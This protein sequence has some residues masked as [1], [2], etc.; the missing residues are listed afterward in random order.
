MSNKLS[1]NDLIPEHFSLFRNISNAF[2]RW[3]LDNAHT[4]FN[5]K[6]INILIYA[7][8]YKSIISYNLNDEI[9]ITEI[10][11]AH[12]YDITNFRYYHKKSNNKYIIMSISGE[13][14]LKLWDFYNWEC[15]LN[16]K[17][18][19]KFGLIFSSCFLNEDN[20]DYILTCGSADQSEIKIYDFSGVFI[21]LINNSSEKT[22]FIDSI[23]DKINSKTYII[24]GND[25]YIK[26]YNYKENKLYHKYKDSGQSWHCSI[27]YI[28]NENVLKL[29]DSCWGDDYIRIWNFHSA[30]LLNKIK[31]NGSNIK[32]ICI[33]NNNCIVIGCYDHT[34]RLIDIKNEKVDKI[35]FG[36]KD[37]V[38]TITKINHPKY[39]ECLISQGIGRNEMIKIWVRNNSY[40]YNDK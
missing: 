28:F 1:K 25:G 5:F 29:I 30:I 37:W 23:F 35:L 6:N 32:S 31:T 7:T 26:S 12:K 10:K 4:I 33:Y 14:N 34:I 38:N 22:L 13:Q 36:H 20:K 40:F 17:S 24:T 19:Y 15:I 21:K 11:N 2:S 8:L 27:K 3:G 16:L 9:I 39:G 18:I